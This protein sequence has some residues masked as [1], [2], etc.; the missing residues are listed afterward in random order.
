MLAGVQAYEAKLRRVTFRECKVHT[1][2]LRGAALRGVV[3]DRCELADLDLDGATLTN[4]SFPGSTARRV[5]LRT[6]TLTKVDLGELP[7]STSSAT[8][9]ACAGRA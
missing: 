4:V 8:A 3:F 9:T 1:L 5:S 7:N 2:N 6:A